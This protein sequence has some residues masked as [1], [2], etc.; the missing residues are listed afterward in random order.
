MSELLYKSDNLSVIWEI[1]E[2]PQIEPAEN[3]EMPVVGILKLIFNIYVNWKLKTF[4]H[5][6]N[7]E[8]S[9]KF[10]KNLTLKQWGEW[11]TIWDILSSLW[12]QIWDFDWISGSHIIIKWIDQIDKK[13]NN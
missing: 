6:F 5:L 8:Y 9:D 4:G 10:C 2:Y 7:L 13:P 11:Q 12:Y 3:I 1:Q